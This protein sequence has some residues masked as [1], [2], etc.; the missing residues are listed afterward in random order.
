LLETLK[1]EQTRVGEWIN[2][3]GYVSPPPLAAGKRSAAEALTEEVRVQAL[4][5]WPTGPLDLDRYQTAL[6]KMK[7]TQQS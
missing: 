2:V 5:L 4:L 7:T 1:Y 3:I 6:D